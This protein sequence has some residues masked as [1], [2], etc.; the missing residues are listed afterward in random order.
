MRIAIDANVLEGAWGGIPKYLTRIASELIAGGDQVSLLANTRRLDRPLPGADEVGIRVKGTVVWREA[1]LPLWLARHRPDVLWAPE[2]QLPRLSPVPS[3]VT[4]HDL[5]SLRFP[6]VKPEDHVRRF[7]TDVARSARRA[8][9]V[10]A[11]SEATAEDI[12]SFYG[13]GADKVRV[14]PNGVDDAFSPGERS[15][16]T[17]AV[18]E[19]WGVAEP[20]VLHVGSLEPRKGV[21]VLIE[22]ATLAR[23]DGAEWRVLL[24]GS[25]G[26]RGEATERLARESGVCTLLGPVGDEELLDLMRAAGALAAPAIYEGFGIAP[27]EA[28]ACGTPTVIAADSGGLVEVSGPASIVVAE[29]TPE[30]WRATIEDALARP[31]SLI[32]AG[33]RHAAK[34]RWPAVAAQTRDVLTEAV[35][36]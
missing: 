19:R 14:V 7:R 29:R 3:V 23:Q 16:A 22:A 34:F 11:V 4:I 6:G 30:A 13:L 2:S 26:F 27:L 8:T 17:A 33:L 28:M 1:F 31:S 12:G 36:R 32:D 24:A 25:T 20:F 21:E 10:I 35:E 15:A 9:R 18:R 5:A